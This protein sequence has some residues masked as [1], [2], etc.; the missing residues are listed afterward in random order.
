VTVLDSHKN[1]LFLGGQRRAIVTRATSA[2]I[3]TAVVF[4]RKTASFDESCFSV[5]GLQNDFLS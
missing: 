5:K 1:R 3:G 2:S 4:V